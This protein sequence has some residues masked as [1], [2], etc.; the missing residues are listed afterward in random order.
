MICMVTIA[1]DIRAKFDA[2]DPALQ[3]A[4]L[5]QGKDLKSVSDLVACLESVIQQEEKKN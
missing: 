4:M 1:P 3:K 5:A 2:L